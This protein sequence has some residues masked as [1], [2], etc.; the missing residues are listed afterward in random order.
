M[1][2]C[3]Y[4]DTPTVYLFKFDEETKKYSFLCG[5]CMAGMIENRQDLFSYKPFRNFKESIIEKVDEYSKCI[6]SINDSNSQFNDDG[7]A[8]LSKQEFSKLLGKFEDMVSNLSENG[9]EIKSKFKLN[10]VENER[11]RKEAFNTLSINLEIKLRSL[12][13]MIEEDQPI[14]VIYLTLENSS[15]P[16][17]L[18]SLLSLRAE[19]NA[20]S[21]S[22]REYGLFLGKIK[23]INED[24][25]A[26]TRK[27]LALKLGLIKHQ[28]N[29]VDTNSE[30]SFR[31]TNSAFSNQ[32][33]QQPPV[34]PNV[35]TNPL[36]KEGKHPQNLLK[37]TPLGES[38]LNQWPGESVTPNPEPNPGPPSNSLTR[39]PR[40]PYYFHFSST[41]TNYTLKYINT[42][43]G[44]IRSH[45]IGSLIDKER[46]KPDFR[47]VNIGNGIFVSG[48]G[49]R[50]ENSHESSIIRKDE[51]KPDFNILVENY[52]KMIYARKRHNLLY[53]E[54]TINGNSKQIVFALS[55]LKSVK[56]EFIYI[57]RD[58][59]W[60]E[61]P[62]LN[63]VRSNASTLF[64]NNFVI[65]YGG[66]DSEGEKTYLNSIEILSLEAL[67]GRNHMWKLI[68]FN[69]SSI[70]N[71]SAFSSLI[72][73]NGQLHIF[74]GFNGSNCNSHFVVENL[75]TN[76]EWDI[77]E[78]SSY[79]PNPTLFLNQDFKQGVNGLYYCCD[80]GSKFYN[81]SLDNLE[82]RQVPE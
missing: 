6:K 3:S 14:N 80:H 55:G 64:Y 68:N 72:L 67:T 28:E 32:N 62:Q 77:K 27:M 46:F 45:Q 10:D 22:R 26:V 12:R 31:N 74:G 66:Y 76:S 60:I 9:N 17:Q 56:C 79:L 20:I 78:S 18:E 81:F 47:Y 19:P 51:S 29:P 69:K 16:N 35:S 13:T 82:V 49:A 58:P 54:A 43:T 75:S 1:I 53:V 63:Y 24:I 7:K 40:F 50:G 15:F 34:I 33:P 38:T 30:F 48:G 36:W 5:N 8:N 39:F 73:P 37:L 41:N 2:S 21:Q 57:E 11:K 59:K 71:K 23:E 44:L 42:Q 4:C 61:L 25:E 52:P 65:L 70:I